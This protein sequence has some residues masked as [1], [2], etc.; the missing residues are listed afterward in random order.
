MGNEEGQ[1]PTLCPP[2]MFDL[3]LCYIL[4]TMSFADVCFPMILLF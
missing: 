4:S 3:S 2:G 1:W